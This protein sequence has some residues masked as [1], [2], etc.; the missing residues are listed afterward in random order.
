M[1][2]KLRQPTGD[3]SGKRVYTADVRQQNEYTW[4]NSVT[5]IKNVRSHSQGQLTWKPRR[6][7]ASWRLENG[8]DLLRR[9]TY[10]KGKAITTN[11]NL[12][13]KQQG[14]DKDGD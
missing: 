11:K 13:S 8:S 10:E 6:S 5:W 14:I 12:Q 4:N 9:V 2:I 3:D 1:L 7:L